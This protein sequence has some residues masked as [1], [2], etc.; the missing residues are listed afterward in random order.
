MNKEN[1]AIIRMNELSGDSPERI[2]ELKKILEESE[3]NEKK[4]SFKSWA[5]IVISTVA[6]VVSILVAIFK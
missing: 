6:L 3:K 2:N 1:E 4:D 5:T